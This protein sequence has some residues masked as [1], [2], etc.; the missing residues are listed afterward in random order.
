MLGLTRELRP[1]S[2]I[3]V[4]WAFRERILRSEPISNG[5][6]RYISGISIQ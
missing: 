1:T 5:D 4:L 3:T 6:Y 2:I